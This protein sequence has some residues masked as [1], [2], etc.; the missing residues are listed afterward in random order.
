[1]S[2]SNH[3]PMVRRINQGVHIGV[4]EYR[5]PPQRKR[6]F[7]AMKQYLNI[8]ILKVFSRSIELENLSL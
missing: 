3:V 6:N 2:V 1:M 8:Q 7:Q 4:H 5:K